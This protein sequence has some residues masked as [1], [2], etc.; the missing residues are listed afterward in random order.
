MHE[1]GLWDF[2]PNVKI[3]AAQQGTYVSFSYQ[4]VVLL[5]EIARTTF[6]PDQWHVGC[7]HYV[8]MLHF[9]AW[10]D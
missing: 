4:L 1:V 5:M 9:A 6:Y 10:N 3:I 2:I 8:A 7:G